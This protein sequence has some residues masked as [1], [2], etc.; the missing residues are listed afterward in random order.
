MTQ[1]LMLQPEDSLLTTEMKGNLTTDTNQNT[2]QINQEGSFTPPAA[3]GTD[4]NLKAAESNSPIQPPLPTLQNKENPSN[5][6][7]TIF[8][9]LALI[10][11]GVLIGVIAAKY[12]PV[13]NLSSEVPVV[14]EDLVT[15]TPVVPSANSEYI[16][17]T[18][19]PV[20]VPTSTPSALLNLKW[21]MLTVKSPVSFSYSYRLYYPTTWTV[22][23]QR[24]IKKADDTGFSSLVLTKGGYSLKILQGTSTE[25]NGNKACVYPDDPTLEGMKQNYSDFKDIFKEQEIR[26]RFSHDSTSTT[27]VIYRVCE[28][29]NEKDY[30]EETVLGYI[31]VTGKDTD[32]A[33]IDEIKYII[34]RI[35]IIKGTLPSASYTCPASGWVDCQPILDVAKQKACSSQAMAWYKENCPDFQGGAL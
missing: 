11:G 29:I 9:G 35:Q 7:H 25:N 34:E 18:P 28:K 27:S 6:L 23:E 32:L 13:S 30:G 8:V 10:L 20:V 2:D 16:Q 21:N 5:L 24:N 14:P 26:W 12:I 22:K 1:D 3:W 31:T 4:T 33:T 17:I 19:T 15:P